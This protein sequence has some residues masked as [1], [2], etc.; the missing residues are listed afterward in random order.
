MPVLQNS[1]LITQRTK[2]R[3]TYDG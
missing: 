3:V 2:K 1:A